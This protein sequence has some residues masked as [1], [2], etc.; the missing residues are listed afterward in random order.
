MN[1]I[2][3][4]APGATLG[5]G[6]IPK[7][8][9]SGIG[10]RLVVFEAFTSYN[11]TD[12]NGKVTVTTRVIT[13]TN[14]DRDEDYYV[15]SDKGAGSITDFTHWVDVNVTALTDNGNS[16]MFFWGVAQINDDF[17]DMGAPLDAIFVGAVHAT[18]TTHYKIKLF[19]VK[20][21][22]L[23]IKN[24]SNPI[25]VGTPSYVSISRNGT[26]ITI[27]IYSTPALRATGGPGDVDTLTGTG[28]VSTAFRYVYGLGSYNQGGINLDISGTVSNLLLVA[29]QQS[30]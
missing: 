24:A 10:G 21:G 25:N 22:G 29:R 14:G 11:E 26:T 4:K 6:S 28:M 19:Q 7:G 30:E 17:K 2:G 12:P 8:L 27:E 15:T 1:G 23:N 16:A 13:L 5:I 20:N 18:A 9:L 3:S